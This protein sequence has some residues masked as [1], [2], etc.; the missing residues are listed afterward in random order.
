MIPLEVDDYEI[1]RACQYRSNRRKRN[2]TRKKKIEEVTE[3]F[4][5]RMILM[6]AERI[7]MTYGSHNV[8]TKLS[9]GML[10]IILIVSISSLMIEWCEKYYIVIIR[11]LYNDVSFAF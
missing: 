8:V 5:S 3:G 6:T 9:A 7:E 4:K 10:E 1:L 11:V 2:S